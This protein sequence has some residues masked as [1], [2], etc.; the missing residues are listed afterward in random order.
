MRSSSCSTLV[1]LAIGAVTLGRASSQA[2]A[3]RAG[4]EPIPRGD[5]VERRED[6]EAAVVQVVLDPLAPRALFARSASERY[7]PVR[8]PVASE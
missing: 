5:L 6:A 1:A 7:F 3:T 8:N 2:I 4:V